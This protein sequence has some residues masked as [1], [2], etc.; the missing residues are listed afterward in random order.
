VCKRCEEA[1]CFCLLLLLLLFRLVVPFDPACP[2]LPCPALPVS[3]RSFPFRRSILFYSV[4]FYS[5]RFLSLH[6]LCYY[7]A[8]PTYL[9]TYL[10]TYWHTY[11]IRLSWIPYLFL[12]SIPIP[13]VLFSCCVRR[14]AAFHQML[15][16]DPSLPRYQIPDTRY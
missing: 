4:L 2:A 12:L 3:L 10:T 7:F 9:P 5:C 15:L 14:F 13:L 11:L 16:F 8:L 1:V 6:T